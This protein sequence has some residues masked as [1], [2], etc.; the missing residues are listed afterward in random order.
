MSIL[1]RCE[2]VRCKTP[3][4]T[5]ALIVTRKLSIHVNTQI[6][7]VALLFESQEEKSILL[8]IVYIAHSPHCPLVTKSNK[9][10]AELAWQ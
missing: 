2:A 9:D 6:C 10:T 8:G 4:Y 5:G 1:T 7:P 3:I